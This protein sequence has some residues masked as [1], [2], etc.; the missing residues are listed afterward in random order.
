MAKPK[1]KHEPLPVVPEDL[2]PTPVERPVPQVIVPPVSA[3]AK[4]HAALVQIASGR[5]CGCRGMHDQSENH[6][7]KT[8]AR[9][10]LE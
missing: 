10:V 9:R 3:E 8:I 4:Y 7:P 6:C 1:P 5:L 2:T